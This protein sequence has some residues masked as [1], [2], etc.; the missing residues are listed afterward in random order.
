MFYLNKEGT[1]IMEAFDI[2]DIAR[3]APLPVLAAGDSHVHPDVEAIH[4]RAL[5]RK[6]RRISAYARFNVEA[7]T[8]LAAQVETD[9]AGLQH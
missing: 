5:R 9:I 4:L 3:S 8:A 7:L 2:A 6:A 1:Y